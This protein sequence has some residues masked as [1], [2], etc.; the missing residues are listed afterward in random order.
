MASIGET[1]SLGKTLGKPKHQI[2]RNFPSGLSLARCCG[3][4]GSMQPWLL[5]M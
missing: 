2:K 4:R 1:A 3:V 5:V